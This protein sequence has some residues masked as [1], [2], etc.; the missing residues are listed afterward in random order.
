MHDCTFAIHI[1]RY[2]CCT[3]CAIFPLF[4]WILGTSLVRLVPLI[5]LHSDA[6]DHSRLMAPNGQGAPCPW[7]HRG[8]PAGYAAAAADVFACGVCAFLLV[9]GKAAMASPFRSWMIFPLQSLV[10]DHGSKPHCG[11]WGHPCASD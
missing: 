4:L 1:Y 8:P 10:G 7:S 5:P 11:C 3:K 6:P 9:M 2:M